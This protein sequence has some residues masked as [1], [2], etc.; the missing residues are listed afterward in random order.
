MLSVPGNEHSGEMLG[1]PGSVE[2]ATLTLPYCVSA[3]IAQRLCA[4]AVNPSQR[5][6]LGEQ[7]DHGVQVWGAA[8]P[9]A[10]QTGGA[11]AHRE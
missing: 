6:S 8:S 2:N 11:I 4:L 1:C 5:R 10:D 3:G 7:P 9:A